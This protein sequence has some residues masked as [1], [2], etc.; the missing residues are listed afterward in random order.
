MHELVFKAI[1]QSQITLI[2]V[3]TDIWLSFTRPDMFQKQKF[4]SDGNI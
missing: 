4:Y 2:Y 3:I 1:A